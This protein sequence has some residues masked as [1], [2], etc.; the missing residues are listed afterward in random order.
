MPKSYYKILIICEGTITEPNFLKPI[1]ENHGFEN[2]VIKI[3]PTPEEENE[4]DDDDLQDYTSK[5]KPKLKKRKTKS[6]RKPKPINTNKYDI[7]IESAGVPLNW[8]LTGKREL[9]DGTAN[10]V[11]CVFDHD[12]HPKRK[13]AFEEAEKP[14]ENGVK[15][16]IAFSS[17]SFEYYLLVHFERIYNKF[18]KTACKLKPAKGK[19]VIIRCGT[20][21]EN[22]CKGKDCING[23]AQT[24]GYWS[25]SD[26]DNSKN[27][28]DFK[29][30]EQLRETSFEN[31]AWVRFQSDKIEP[32]SRIYERNPYLNTDFLIKRLIQNDNEYR[33]I[34]LDKI[35]NF[36]NELSI[37]IV[38]TQVLITNISSKTV[39]FPPNQICA[40]SENQYNFG[41]RKII[42][43]EDTIRIDLSEYIK[44]NVYFKIFYENYIIM[45]EGF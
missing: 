1:V 25:N 33:W 24:K 5:N 40:I 17:R 44:E 11:W 32:E 38:N 29:G 12:D 13:E 45:F 4:E 39:V 35:Y 34:D 19:T 23:Y 7:Q 9:Y 28:A 37:Q 31:S 8:V 36:K 30:F 2:T 18:E 21:V 41:E 43:P 22:D 10:E 42:S 3:E 16:N 20:G 6:V 15:V 14:L 27:Q 26:E